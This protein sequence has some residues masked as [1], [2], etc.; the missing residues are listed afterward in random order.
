MISIRKDTLRRPFEKEHTQRQDFSLHSVSLAIQYLMS[1]AIW[2]PSIVLA[3]SRDCWAACRIQNTRVL[4]FPSYESIIRFQIS[5]HDVALGQDFE[6]SFE[7][8]F[9]PSLWKRTLFSLLDFPEFLH[10]RICIRSKSCWPFL[11]CRYTLR[12][13]DKLR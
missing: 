3:I 2:Q 6:Q 7:S 8:S 10:C 12:C 1:H 13:K 9:Y 4:L 5:M 11:A